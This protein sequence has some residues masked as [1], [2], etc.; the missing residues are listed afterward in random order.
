M[1]DD[2]KGVEET[3]VDAA[4]GY[5]QNE[6]KDRCRRAA[7]YYDDNTRCSLFEDAKFVSIPT[8][9]LSSIFTLSPNHLSTRFLP[10]RLFYVISIR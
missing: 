8:K 7:V 10:V 6:I 9:D 5:I 2:G 3:R 4:L 1:T